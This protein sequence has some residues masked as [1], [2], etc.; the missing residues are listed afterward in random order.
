MTRQLKGQR[1]ALV[2]SHAMTEQRGRL[3]DSVLSNVTAGVIG[4]DGAGTIAFVNR[5]GARLLDLQGD[6]AGRP[7]AAVVPDR[8]AWRACRD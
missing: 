6:P 8:P 1:D 5:A 2:D 7:L 3:F 4:L